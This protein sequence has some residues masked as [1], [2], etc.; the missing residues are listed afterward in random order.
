M[1]RQL[2]IIIGCLAVGELVVWLTGVSVPSSIM[3]M[4]LLTTMLKTKVV[5]SE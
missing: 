3:G 2:A 4:L 1:F 5:N